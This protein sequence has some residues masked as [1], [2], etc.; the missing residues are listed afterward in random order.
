M[1]ASET[2]KPTS[3][4]IGGGLAGLA[5]A[6]RS[7]RHGIT[8]MLLEKRGYLGGRAF[9]FTDRETGIV[10]DNG[11][12]IFLGACT[13]YIDFI[14]EIGARG[15]LFEQKRLEVPALKNGV[16]SRLGWSRIPGMGMLP[17]LLCYRHLGMAGKLRVI[18]GMIRIRLT[19]RQKNAE[20]LNQQTFQSWLEARCQ[21]ESTI[22][23]L[24]NLIVLPSL[25]DDIGDVSADAGLMLFQTA[26]MG[27]GRDAIIGY[28]R[29]GLSELA[30]KHGM[31][32]VNQHDGEIRLDTEVTSLWFEGEAL[33]GVRLADGSTLEADAVITA[34]P[35]FALGSLLPESN[36]SLAPL[37]KAASLETAP[38]VGIHIWY[39]RPILD[40]PFIA[41]LDSPLQFIFNVTAIQSGAMEEPDGGQH[42]VISLSGAWRWTQMGRRE[43]EEVFV[44]EMSRAFPAASAERVTRF[45]SVKQVDATFRVTPGSNAARLPQSTAIPNLFLAG[46][47]TDTDWPSTME[48]AVRSGNLAADAAAEH[49]SR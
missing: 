46:D 39:D 16:V 1:A 13:D 40:D 11:Q 34:V 23:N 49:L 12:H 2:R 44:E 30:G 8:P 48:S 6:T 27:S 22:T 38:I 25:N 19:S 20:A 15:S 33:R 9:S 37:A 24:W 18:Y 14:S 10:V 21:N 45:L 35:H 47:W 29:V 42:V 26:L 43:L 3:I 4:I 32:Y 5:A 28:S 31:A 7:I 36:Q 17:S 41:V